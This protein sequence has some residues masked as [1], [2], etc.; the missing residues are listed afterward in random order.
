MKCFELIKTNK[1][2]N[3]SVLKLNYF[4]FALKIF[5]LKKMKQKRWE[6]AV[7]IV[8]KVWHASCFSMLVSICISIAMSSKL[9]EEKK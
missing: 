7:F 8:L 2:R 1:K 4:S 6:L 5:V 9:K 3:S